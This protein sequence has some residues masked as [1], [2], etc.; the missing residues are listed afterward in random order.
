MLRFYVF[1]HFYHRPSRQGGRHIAMQ[2]IITCKKKKVMN[3]QTIAANATER[4]LQYRLPNSRSDP[5]LPTRIGTG[6]IPLRISPP[7]GF[8]QLISLLIVY[9]GWLICNRVKRRYQL[10]RYRDGS[11]SN[12]WRTG[13]E[14]SNGNWEW[15]LGFRKETKRD[16]LLRAIKFWIDT[17]TYLDWNNA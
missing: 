6:R 7:S 2:E 5:L 8:W 12:E 9:N 14:T 13:K 15:K 4:F 16:D 11:R 3:N 10:Q 1:I 17:Q